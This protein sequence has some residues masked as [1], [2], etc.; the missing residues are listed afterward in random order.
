MKKYVDAEGIAAFARGAYSKP[1]IAIVASGASPSNLS[2]WVGE[3]FNDTPSATVAGSFSPLTSQPTKYFGG[4]E[5]ISNQAGNAM[6]IAFPG[7][8]FFGSAAYKPEVEVLAALLGGESTIKWSSGLSLLSKAAE[9]HP[10]AQVSTKH[11]AYSDA[12][13]LYI[14]ITGK[15]EAV[16]AA[17]KSVVSKIKEVAAGKIASEDIKKATALAKFRALEAGQ[18]IGTGVELNG[19]SLIHTGKPYHVAE[20][21]QSIDKVTEQQVKS[22]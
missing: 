17:S 8:G 18:T 15:A 10:Q 6:V 5:R 13:L 19:A 1:S 16:G 11:A 2:K 20:V 22:V 7:S 14:A 3:F 9:A 21:G 4:E 12:G